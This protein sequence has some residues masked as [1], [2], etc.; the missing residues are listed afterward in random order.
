MNQKPRG[1]NK[2]LSTP[3]IKSCFISS[4]IVETLFVCLTYFISLKLYN[5]EKNK[6]SSDIQKVDNSL[7]GISICHTL[8]FKNDVIYNFRKVMSKQGFNFDTLR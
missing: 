5:N 6:R 4:A 1:L 7:P 8:S 3:F 2:S